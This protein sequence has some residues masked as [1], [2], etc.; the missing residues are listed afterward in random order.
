MEWF[1]QPLKKAIQAA[2]VAGNVWR[3]ELN[4]YLLKYRIIPHCI[5]KKLFVSRHKDAR[6]NEK[7]RQVYHKL[8]ADNRRKVKESSIKVGDTVL[9][10]QK[11]KDKSSTHFITTPYVVVNRKGSQVIADVIQK[12]RVKRN[13]SHFKKFKNAVD[14]SEETYSELEDEIV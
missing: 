4:R 3:Q 11:C 12:H 8:Y 1:N 7:K 13:V 2:V 14:R 6:E 9:G 10:R 5:T